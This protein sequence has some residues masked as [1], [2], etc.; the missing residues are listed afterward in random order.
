MSEMKRVDNNILAEGEVTGHY[1]QAIGDD[2]SVLEMDGD[3]RLLTAPN[4]AEITHQEHNKIT[5]PPGDYIR[6]IVVEHD[7]FAEEI[8]QVRD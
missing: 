6:S 7:P 5:L 3:T 2:V 1:H 4:G 8:R